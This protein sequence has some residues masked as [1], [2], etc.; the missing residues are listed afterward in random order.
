MSEVNT[1]AVTPSGLT[2]TVRT[3]S[4]VWGDGMGLTPGTAVFVSVLICVQSLFC[5]F[6]VRSIYLSARLVFL[7]A[8]HYYMFDHVF[9]LSDIPMRSRFLHGDIWQREF[10]D[11]PHALLCCSMSS[12]WLGHGFSL[13]LFFSSRFVFMKWGR[14]SKS[15]LH[16]G[17][18]YKT[19]KGPFLSASPLTRSRRHTFWKR[20]ITIFTK[21]VALEMHFPWPVAFNIY[22]GAVF[23]MTQQECL[24]LIA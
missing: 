6:R 11:S 8:C 15:R 22:W 3:A 20:Q 18:N 12:G 2:A 14:G 23:P 5:R 17:K 10:E 7:S 1:Y 4:A 16:L 19:L 13:R 9:C 21:M 24:Q